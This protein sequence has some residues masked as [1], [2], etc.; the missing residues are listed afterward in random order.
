[1]SGRPL[2]VVGLLA[3]EAGLR[4]LSDALLGTP[5]LELAAVLT[6]GALPRAEGGGRRTDLDDFERLCG[7]AQVPLH[8]IDG[9]E[10]RDITPRLPTGP[11]DLMVSVSWRYLV[12][13]D[14][15]DAF[16]LGCVNLHR[17]DLPAYAG[18]EPVRRAIEA[19]ERRV[20]ITAHRMS[21][22]IDAGPILAQVWMDAPALPDSVGSAAHAETIKAA[23]LPLYAPLATLGIAAAY[24]AADPP[25]GRCR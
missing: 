5:G 18:A 11:L 13:Q 4:V 8:A 3:R 9:R 14:V 1:V 15:L 7:A 12:G 19:G 6:H 16:A 10:A 24:A 22:E 17:G 25:G 21:A 2:R 20:A 23:L